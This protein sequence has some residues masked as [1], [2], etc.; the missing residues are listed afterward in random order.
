[1]GQGRDEW[2]MGLAFPPPGKR[3]KR[4]REGVCVLSAL[5]ISSRWR[6][7]ACVS[8]RWLSMRSR[9]ND[10]RLLFPGSTRGPAAVP[11][12]SLC[13]WRASDVQAATLTA[14]V[15]AVRRRHRPS[16]RLPVVRRRHCSALPSR[17]SSLCRRRIR[18]CFS[19]RWTPGARPAESVA[20][21]WLCVSSAAPGCASPRPHAATRVSDAEGICGCPCLRDECGGRERRG[22]CPPRSLLLT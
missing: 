19:L 8:S 4:L 22:T 16:P 15:H 10:A 17:S 11:R 14:T 7:F 18:T 1:M 20:A 2:R 13:E 6:A 9:A 12:C 5:I 3:L 21:S